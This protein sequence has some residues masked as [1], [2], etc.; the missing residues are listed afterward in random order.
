ML[1]SVLYRRSFVADG[2]FKAD[3]LAPRNAEDDMHLTDGEAF[4]TQQADYSEHLKE[5]ISLAPRYAQKPTC[6]QHRAIADSKKSGP[7]KRVRG[8][9]AHACAPMQMNM[10]YSNSQAMKT[11]HMEEID[12]LLDIYDVN[13]QYCHDGL[14][15]IFAI[16]LFHVHGHKEEC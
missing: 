16:G 9:G 10:D 4:M 7:G 14:T 12:E 13:C 1:N 8:C 5:A 6:H 15:I 11:T 2:N 3:H